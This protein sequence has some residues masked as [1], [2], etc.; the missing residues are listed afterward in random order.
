[1]G[2]KNYKKVTEKILVYLIFLRGFFIM[3]VVDN[4]P[5]N[6]RNCTIYKKFLG[7]ACPAQTSLATSR[8]FADRD[9][10]QAACKPKIQKKNKVGPPPLGS[11]VYAPDYIK[12]LDRESNPCM[13][14]H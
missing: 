7:G 9:M 4:S 10:P 8:S 14:A 12:T 2:E 6:A 1:M 3:K 11:P 5:Q 13:I